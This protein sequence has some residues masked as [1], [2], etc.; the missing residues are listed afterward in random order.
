MLAT[1]I[2]GIE[3]ETAGLRERYRHA[4]D[5]AAFSFDAV[6][7]GD[8]SLARQVDALTSTMS[9]YT[10][11]VRSLEAQA[12]SS[13]IRSA[14]A[15]WSSSPAW[16]GRSRKAGARAV[17]KGGPTSSDRGSPRRAHLRLRH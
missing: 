10:E 15:S 4:R 11:R 9:R 16:T 14:R 3:R 7:N 13:C 17:S 1:Q 5:D 6:E 12:A 8:P 2:S